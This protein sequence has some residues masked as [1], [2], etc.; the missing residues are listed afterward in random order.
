MKRM[1]VGFLLGGLPLLVSSCGSGPTNLVSGIEGSGITQ[2]TAVSSAGVVTELGSIFVNGVRYDLTGA[3]I[4][5]DGQ[6][7]TE[8]ALG[9]GSIV[10]VE[11]TLDADGT[12]GRALRVTAGT[13]VA[14]PIDFVAI[15]HDSF[16]VLGQ[17]VVVDQATVIE[18]AIDGL[19]L[20]GLTLD[21]DVEVSGFVDSSGAITARRISPRREETA[22]LL[23]G[24]VAELD[25]AN[26]RF[27]INDATVDYAN[28]PL[29]DFPGGLSDGV[30]VRVSVAVV[31]D[32]GVLVADEV[33]YRDLRMPGVAGDTATLQG[34]VTRYASATDFDVDGRRVVASG[35]VLGGFVN[36]IALD[37]FVTISGLITSNGAVDY[38]SLLTG[39]PP[40][41]WVRNAN[42]DAIVGALVTIIQGG[43]V[44]Q[45]R[46]DVNGIAE[47]PSFGGGAGVF[48]VSADGYETL[49][50]E[51]GLRYGEYYGLSLAAV[52]AWQTARPIVLG[53]EFID[54]AGNGST[55]TFSV[56]LAVIDG[57]A[58]AIQTLTSTDFS[59][60]YF[61]CGW[62][63]PLDCASDRNGNETGGYYLG[64]Q[65]TSFAGLQPPAARQPYLVEILAVRSDRYDWRTG[66]PYWETLA[67]ALRRFVGAVG[68]NDR[69]A[70]S[71]VQLENGIA[72]HTVLGPF[73]S[74]G[75]IYFDAIDRLGLPAG[76]DWPPVLQPLSESI[77]RAAAARDEALPGVKAN[78]LILGQPW[79]SFEETTALSALARENE[80]RIS[81]VEYWTTYGIPKVAEQSDGLVAWVSDSRQFTMVFDAMDALLAGALPFYRMEFVLRGDPGTFVA[82]GNAKVR[83]HIDAPTTLPSRGLEAIVDVAIP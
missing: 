79:L 7:T 43:T 21:S 42:G 77:G 24:Y 8:S 23:T 16:T 39:G 60:G 25:Q 38:R 74:D 72:T 3:M 76:H 37:E 34:W 32:D 29:I 47:F 2:R 26:L 62:G 81:T 67:P 30:P 73:T 82:G 70:L 9:V 65:P 49:I 66:R 45:A 59:I 31:D 40:K 18:N 83:I 55:L 13:A 22:L 36:D 14:G 35:S 75:S 6:L 1:F 15:T 56:D 71:S 53:T 61:D 78:V 51:G 19:P 64:G 58:A 50:F 28:A 80:V 41:V 10:V 48:T 63:G 33:T 54:R 69:V 57:S 27:A 11:G 4:T 46:T 12:T 44:Y 17:T 68:G 52:G 20:G 5:L